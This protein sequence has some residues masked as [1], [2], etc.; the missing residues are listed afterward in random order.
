MASDQDMD[1][2]R[3]NDRLRRESLILK[4]ERN[5]PKKKAAQFFAVQKP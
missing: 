1:L 4:E 2:A 5:I 3:E